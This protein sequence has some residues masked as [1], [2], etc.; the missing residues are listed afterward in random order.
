VVLLGIV[1]SG[2]YFASPP[3][4]PWREMA[5]LVRREK[6]EGEAVVVA[7]PPVFATPFA[8]YYEGPLGFEDVGALDVPAE[9]PGVWV[10]YRFADR[11]DPERWQDHPALARWPRRQVHAFR[12]GAVVHCQR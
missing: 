7:E 10:C 8:Y 6:V 11:V 4:T 12:R 3:F 5:A 2:L 9:V 1:S